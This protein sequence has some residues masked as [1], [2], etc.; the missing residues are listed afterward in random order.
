M[1][2]VVIIAY[3]RPEYL[4]RVLKSIK[5]SID[6]VF[7]G[8]D[9][10]NIYLF[11]DG[12]KDEQNII[13]S[14]A[15]YEVFAKY[16]PRS[17][18]H[19]SDK[20]I[21]ILKNYQRAEKFIFDDLGVDFS[22]FFEDDLI[23]GLDYFAILLRYV[24]LMKSH[25]RI[26]YAACY[27]ENKYDNFKRTSDSIRS[28]D[29]LGHHWG[30]VASKISY[31]SI[32]KYQLEYLNILQ[33][34]SYS[35]KE[36]R[37]YEIEKLFKSWGSNF[38]EISQDCMKAIALISEGYIKINSNFNLGFNIGKVGEHMTEELFNSLK[39]E[40]GC[41]NFAPAFID[42]DEADINILHSHLRKIYSFIN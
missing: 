2:P 15:C 36:A 11:L 31:E 1:Y 25:P 27:G 8:S 5:N 33:D 16:F 38:T 41:L 10:G 23:V 13:K 3:N 39:W 7:P 42:I 19:Q 4:D 34:I 24:Q 30:F 21:G 18:I 22:F 29:T 9:Y 28:P 12:G 14:N 32:K 40:E 35:D 6:H 20:N 37:R 17:G 26:A